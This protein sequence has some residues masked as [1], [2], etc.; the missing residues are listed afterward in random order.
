MNLFQFSFLICGFQETVMM[1]VT[2]RSRLYVLQT[3]LLG[4]LA[5]YLC[6]S[7]VHTGSRR[8]TLRSWFPIMGCSSFSCAIL[9]L[10]QQ[11]RLCYFLASFSSV[12]LSVVNPEPCL[13][14]DLSHMFSTVCE[15]VRVFFLLISRVMLVWTRTCRHYV[16]PEQFS[17]SSSWL[18]TWHHSLCFCLYSYLVI[19]Q[20]L[21]CPSRF[22]ASGL[23]PLCS[24]PWHVPLHSRGSTCN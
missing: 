20:R 8:D 17:Q 24:H 19:R 2:G 6:Y 11:P 15:Y 12:S 5:Y 14:C 7:A 10:G 21:C 3:M 1:H 16:H 18:N 4:V 9:P 13:P 22:L 23:P